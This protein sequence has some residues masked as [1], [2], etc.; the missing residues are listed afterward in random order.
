MEIFPNL[1]KEI[2]IQVQE[3]QKVPIK[4]NPERPTRRHTIIKMVKLKD[5]EN[6]KAAKEKCYLPTKLFPQDSQLISQQKLCRSEGIDMKC[7]N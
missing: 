7:S 4:I 5:R 6:L 1:V 3:A 2:D